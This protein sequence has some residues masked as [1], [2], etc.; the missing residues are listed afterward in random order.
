MD[1]HGGTALG[2]KQPAP[3]GYADIDFSA[4]L[5]F[6]SSGLIEFAYP[7]CLR[8]DFLN[9][10]IWGIMTTCL[11]ITVHYFQIQ[12]NLQ[13]VNYLVPLDRWN[14]HVILGYL[15]VFFLL[16]EWDHSVFQT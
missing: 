11:C 5:P 12:R 8:I 6:C 7:Q 1:G 3:P 14:F 4:W 2:E 10:E 15:R 13:R 16:I 9:E